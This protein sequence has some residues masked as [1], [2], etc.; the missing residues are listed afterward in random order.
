MFV[1]LFAPGRT[2]KALLATIAGALVGATLLWWL[3]P[4]WPAVG[5]T[6]AALPGIRPVDLATASGELGGQGL[7]AFLNGPL[8]G[9]PV[10]VYIHGAALLGQPLAGVLL[11]VALNR[12]E[13]VGL[14]AAVAWFVGTIFR[15]PIARHPGMVLVGYVG[16]TVVIY[17]AYFTLR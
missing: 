7:G 10:K 11:M 13:R 4:A 6:I 1:A 3:A 17:G 5:D 14:S 16:L 15:R 12:L 9:L 2:L 8:Q